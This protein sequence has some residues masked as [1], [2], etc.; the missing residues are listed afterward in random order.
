MTYTWADAVGNL[1]VLLVLLSYLALQLER[2]DGRGFAYSACNALGA[3]L[4][5][6]SLIVNFNL[7]S[8]VI[9]VFWLAISLF[10]VW[11]A[12]QRRRKRRQQVDP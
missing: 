12:G 5:L 2:I 1:G 4:L 7:S 3:L 11:R 10:G 8:V 6:V 9:E